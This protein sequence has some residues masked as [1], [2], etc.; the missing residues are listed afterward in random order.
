MSASVVAQ[1]YE[2]AVP[3]TDLSGVQFDAL[4]RL[5]ARAGSDQVLEVFCELGPD[6]AR[7]LGREL[8]R[9]ADTAPARGDLYQRALV[10]LICADLAQPFAAAEPS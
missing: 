9:A 8:R 2:D 10:A 3:D 6:T 1:L 5:L 7:L 4:V